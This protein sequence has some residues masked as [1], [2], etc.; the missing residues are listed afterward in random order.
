MK[1]DATEPNRGGFNYSRGDQIVNRALAR[2]QRVRGHALLWH[3]Q[4]PGWTANLSGG[5]LR[6]AM[7]RHV[8]Q[9]ASYYR[10]KVFA[11]DVVNE[12]FADDGG[13]S[14]RDS[15]LQ[16]TGNDWIEVAFRTARAADPTTKL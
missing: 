1:W 7:N 12:A 4:Q 2:G 6:N 13:G 14:R 10:G 9:V 8:T 16:R 3:A 5:D 11:W 15:N